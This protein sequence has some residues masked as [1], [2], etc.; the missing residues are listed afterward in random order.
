MNFDVS[1]KTT[2][3]R[4]SLVT[5]FA[6]MF[7]SSLIMG[8]HVSHQMVCSSIFRGTNWAIPEEEF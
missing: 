4:K 5:N 8:F 1:V 6:R 3:L 7:P 2:R